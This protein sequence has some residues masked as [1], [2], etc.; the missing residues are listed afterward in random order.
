[1]MRGKNEKGQIALILVLAATV[2]GTLI[3]SLAD[4]STRDL[5]T[6][7]LDTEKVKALKGAES[8]VEQALL[9][10]GDVI[11]SNLGDGV[12]FEADY[13]NEGSNGIVSDLVN[14]GDVIDVLIEGADASL[15]S[16]SI[17]FSS[18]SGLAALKVSEF[19][20]DYTVNSYAF[21]GDVSRAIQ[22]NFS[23]AVSRTGFP[24][25]QVNFADRSIVSID[26]TATKL[27]RITVLYAATK[28]GI[29]PI[30]GNLPNQQVVISSVGY[31]SVSSDVSV[32]KRLELKK[33]MEKVPVVFDNVLYSNSKL[34]Q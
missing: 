13:A 9:S 14:P 25:Q 32:K 16:V 26:P 24:Y 4:R 22:N 7:T 23:D 30:G 8:G 34:I 1:M 17:Y 20:S 12:G 18:E 10:G 3:I 29:L 2:A 21:D 31:Y 6:Q 11:N 27:L 15:S 19:K 5:R 33:E 28:I